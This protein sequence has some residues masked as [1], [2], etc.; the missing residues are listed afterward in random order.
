MTAP[1]FLDEFAP[2]KVNL[3]L[4][5]CGRRDDGYHLLDSLV[6]F[7]GGV[8]DRIE[9]EPAEH[10]SFSVSGPFGGGFADDESGGD[11]QSKNLV[12]RAAMMMAVA[13][14]R[15]PGIKIHLEKNLPLASGIGGGSADA[16]AV[17]RG[18]LRHW[19]ID[20]PT[21]L[22]QILLRLGADVPVCYA[23]VAAQM[24]GI[25]EI[26]TS[27]PALP[28]TPI[29]LVNPGVSCPTAEIFRRHKKIWKTERALP[30]RFDDSDALIAFLN[31]TSND[32]QQAAIEYAP[33]IADALVEM[34]K[35]PGCRLTRMSGSGATIFALFNDND[36]RAAAEHSLATAHPD[37]W[38]RGG[39][40]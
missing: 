33:I 24:C 17:A 26:I 30:P 37:W 36:A 25:G 34:Q 14:G 39:T 3:Y 6:A 28:T 7:V 40:L 21:D 22:P 38:V 1:P 20:P 31:T 10:F 27:V 15:D 13:L 8:G 2:A 18:L 29:L 32:L 19:D 23:G 4:H 11:A 12:V 35:Y 16:A 9:I 5:L